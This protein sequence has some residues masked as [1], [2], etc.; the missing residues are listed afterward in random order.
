MNEWNRSNVACLVTIK[1]IIMIV[2][3]DL[4]WIIISSWFL[5]YLGWRDLSGEIL[6]KEKKRK[7]KERKKERK[8][9]LNSKFEKY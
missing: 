3:S 5:I 6:D 1:G 4:A 8:N 2:S 7:K 9:S